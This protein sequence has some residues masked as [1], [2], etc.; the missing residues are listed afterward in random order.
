VSASY[1]Y[2]RLNVRVLELDVR[3]GRHAVGNDTRLVAEAGW[4]RVALEARGKEQAHTIGSTQVEVVADD[5]FK[6]V[7]PVDGCGED[8]RQAHLEL[9][10]A[11]TVAKAGCSIARRQ[12]PGQ[13]LQPAIEE[14]VHVGGAERTGQQLHALGVSTPQEAVV[15]AVERDALLAQLLFEPLIAVEAYPDRIGQVGADFAEG[16]SPFEVLEK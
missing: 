2:E 10:D 3:T 13:T 16:W 7:A 11:E 8:V 4:R 6:E 15:E 1:S 12:W 5:R 9:P 14:R